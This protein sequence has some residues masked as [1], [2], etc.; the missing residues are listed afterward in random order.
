[1]LSNLTIY[2]TFIAWYCISIYRWEMSGK[3][4][5]TCMGQNKRLHF[6]CKAVVDEMGW[7]ILKWPLAKSYNARL[8][9]DKLHSGCQ[10]NL[11][12]VFEHKV[13]SRCMASKK[14]TLEV[15]WQAWQFRRMRI[16]F[17]D[18][19][20][21]TINVVLRSGIFSFQCMHS[22]HCLVSWVI[23]ATEELHRTG[24]SEVNSV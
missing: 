17:Q 21:P 20:L 18:K 16:Q 10:Q 24:L 11:S 12:P 23:D 19:D 22:Y 8:K 9:V 5:F 7:N 2:Y 14:F 6:C 1:M 3:S 13:N 15:V 4:I